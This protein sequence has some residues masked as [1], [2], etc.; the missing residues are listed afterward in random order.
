MPRAVEPRKNYYWFDKLYKNGIT[1]VASIQNNIDASKKQVNTS[2]KLRLKKH[3]PYIKK[4]EYRCENNIGMKI[5]NTDVWKNIVYGTLKQEVRC[6]E[7][8]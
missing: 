8:A 7:T 6:F 4:I 3:R 5:I 1:Q 2:C